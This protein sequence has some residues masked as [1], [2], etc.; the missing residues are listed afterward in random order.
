MLDVAMDRWSTI[1]PSW[2]ISRYLIGPVDPEATLSDA[3]CLLKDMNLATRDVTYYE[4]LGLPLSGDYVG[5][6]LIPD[7]PM[8]DRMMA[9]ANH[10]LSRLANRLSIGR[11][12][13]WRYLSGATKATNSNLGN[14]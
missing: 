14:H 7:V 10:F 6:Q 2:D 8:L 12:L 13:C 1:F 5:P 9:G 4:V 3:V 11:W